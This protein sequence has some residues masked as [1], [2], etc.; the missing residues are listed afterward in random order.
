M[1]RGA[2]D[3]LGPEQAGFIDSIGLDLYLK[4]LNEVIEEKKTGT[5][6]EPP[7]PMKMFSIDAYIPE[8]YASDEEKI[9]LYQEIDGAKTQQELKEIKKKI[10]D[11]Y[12]R[13]PDEVKLLIDRKRVDILVKNEEIKDVL[14]YP[15]NVAVILSKKFSAINGIG[16]ELFD[17][18]QEYMDVIKVSFINKELKI[19]ILKKNNWFLTLETILDVIH[20]LYLKRKNKSNED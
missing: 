20:K 10:R 5:P 16:M 14:E 1:I 8:G 12:G 3:I 13:L 7:K 11:I 9:Q 19:T 17:A 4:L 15:D 2:G 18:I 6:T